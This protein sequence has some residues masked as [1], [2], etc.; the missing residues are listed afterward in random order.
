MLRVLTCLNSTSTADAYFSNT[1][2][3]LPTG[4]PVCDISFPIALSTHAFVPG[5]NMQKQ[6]DLVS[7]TY[8]EKSQTFSYDRGSRSNKLSKITRFSK[9]LQTFSPVKLSVLREW[10][11]VHTQR[12]CKSIP[13][14]P[15]KAIKVI[16]FLRLY[17]EHVLQ[18]I[19][20]Q[21]ILVVP[22]LCGANR[23]KMQLKCGPLKNS[24]EL[25]TVHCELTT[26]KIDTFI[27]S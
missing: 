16:T 24:V 11:Q 3:M 8:N 26:C 13:L 25:S 15:T 18:V 9:Y 20:S 5:S 19:S 6:I 23:Q 1:S 4:C 14:A 12:L 22:L 27:D 2:L 17:T 10:P 7:L 21:W